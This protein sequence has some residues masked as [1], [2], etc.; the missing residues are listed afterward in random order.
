MKRKTT[1]QKEIIQRRKALNKEINT[2][3]KKGAKIVLKKKLV[4]YKN[5]KGEVGQIYDPSNNKFLRGSIFEKE[6]KKHLEKL[7]K[8]N[9]NQEK[10]LINQFKKSKV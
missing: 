10:L 4:Y 8:T 1:K 3:N 7:F 9:E 2:R 6:R 5:S